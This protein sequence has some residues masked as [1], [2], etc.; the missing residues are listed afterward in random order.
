MDAAEFTRR[1]LAN[2]QDSIKQET[3]RIHEIAAQIHAD[4]TIGRDITGDAERLVQYATSLVR[5]S[6]TLRG[7][8]DVAS[9]TTIQEA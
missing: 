7:M 6:A 5:R 3:E 8:R 2:E 1:Q 9:Y 4:A